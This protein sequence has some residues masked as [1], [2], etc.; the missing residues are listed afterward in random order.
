MAATDTMRTY[1]KSSVRETRQRKNIF[2]WFLTKNL[3]CNHFAQGWSVFEAV[4]RTT[5]E[6]PQVVCLRMLVRDEITVGRVRVLTDAGFNQGCAF[7]A[8]KTVSDVV[9]GSFDAFG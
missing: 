4:S 1:N 6:Q 5:T 2:D 9:A 8:R 3:C 7:E